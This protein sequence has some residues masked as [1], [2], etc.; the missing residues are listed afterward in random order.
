MHDNRRHNERVSVS[1]GIILESLSGTRQY[2]ISD[3]S[4]GG[5]YIDSI[6]P[7]SEGENVVFRVPTTTGHWL[8]LSGKTTYVFPGSGFGIKFDRLS[9]DDRNVLELIIISHGGQ[10]I[11]HTDLGESESEFDDFDR[12][13]QE[14]R[15]DK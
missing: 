11:K 4:M 10:P 1:L 2:R 6:T 9:A 13:I 5:C 3:I 15:K 12:F 14:V 7:L 8:R